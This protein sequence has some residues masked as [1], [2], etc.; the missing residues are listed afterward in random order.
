V[1]S[2]KDPNVIVK[3]SPGKLAAGEVQASSLAFPLSGGGPGLAA[4]VI[5][6]L[7]A[8]QASA[9]G[10]Q[11]GSAWADATTNP[12]TTVEDQLDKLVTDLAATAGAAR[13]G[14]ASTGNFAD[15]SPA[16]GADIQAL[17]NSVVAKLA[18]TAGAARVGGAA[19][20]ASFSGA[21][22]SISAQAVN[23]QLSGLLAAI[24][25]EYRTRTVST[26]TT[27]DSGGIRDKVVFMTVGTGSGGFTLTLPDP[28]SNAGRVLI[29]I[30][31]LGNLALGSAVT[32]A[33][34]GSEKINNLESNY[35]LDATYGRWLVVCD[36]ANW[37]I[38]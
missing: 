15:G 16:T 10:Y 8:H 9:I 17:I 20:A 14:A 27:L 13:V 24:N 38:V 23:S 33:R 29:L 28:A 11:G 35:V 22:W 37:H 12:A 1:P 34:F 21:P 30:D 19:S 18:A 31:T 25:A 7:D 3:P 36:G 26:S 6:P 2:T 32:L 5:D 4:H